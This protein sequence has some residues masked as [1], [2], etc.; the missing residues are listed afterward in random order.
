MSYFRSKMKIKT[1]F[2]LYFSYLFVT[3]PRIYIQMQLLVCGFVAE[4]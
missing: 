2:I 3:L 4:M 1:C